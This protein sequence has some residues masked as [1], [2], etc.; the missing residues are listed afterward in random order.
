MRLSRSILILVPASAGALFI[1]TAAPVGAI[2]LACAAATTGCQAF[3]ETGS[4]QAFAVPAGV[5]GVTVELFGAGGGGGW[6]PA[7]SGSVSAGAP[8]GLTVGSLTTTPGSTLEVVVGGVGTNGSA[9]AEGSGG[10]NGGGAAVAGFGGGGGGGATDIRTGSCAATSP[11]SCTTDDRVLVAGGGGGA[12]GGTSGTAGGPGGGTIGAAGTRIDEFTTGGDAGTQFGPGAGGTGAAQSGDPGD[13]STGVVGDGGGGSGGGGG[14]GGGGYHGGGGGADANPSPG[15]Y[16]GSGGGGGSGYLSA[17]TPG[18]T[19]QL[20]PVAASTNGTATIYWMTAPTLTV[21][22]G[23]S[24]TLTANTPFIALAAAG[25]HAVTLDG[26]PSE[27]TETFTVGSTTLCQ[28]VAVVDGA[29]SCTTSALP[30]G[31]DDVTATLTGPA[32]VGSFTGTGSVTLDSYL[33]S[34]RAGGGAT[35]D[36]SLLDGTTEVLAVTV[37][38]APTATPSPTA[39]PTAAPVPVSGAEPSAGIP[40]GV[41]LVGL[42]LI[43]AGGAGIAATRRRRRAH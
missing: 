14:G 18:V 33:V 5:V 26:D 27:G 24:V 38:A 32:E 9:S 31:T 6:D 41:P 10:Y 4:P 34:R 2:P 1:G 40:A 37:A 7:G 28:G 35:L 36:Q 42:L 16:N 22:A 20:D 8:G 30:V 11:P 25:G 15:E 39:T 43:L 12:G 23:D 17:G 29:A 19:E 21:T 3:S 13:P